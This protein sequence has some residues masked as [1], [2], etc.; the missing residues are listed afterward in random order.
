MKTKNIAAMNDAAALR[1]STVCLS[2]SISGLG[3]TRKVA[4]GEVAPA[5]CSEDMLHVHKDIVESEKLTKVR[6]VQQRMRAAVTSEAT[7]P[8]WIKGGFYLVPKARLSAI[9]ARLTDIDA[10]MKEAVAAFVEEYPAAV[11]ASK[12]KL[13]PLAKD[14][15]YPDV[16]TVAAAFSAS[17]FTV[18]LGPAQNVDDDIRAI[19]AAKA[20]KAWAEAVSEV[21]TILRL[22]MLDLVN[23]MS[24]LTAPPADG[25]L[26]AFRGGPA[27]DKLVAFL[28]EW[29]LRNVASDADLDAIVA[30]AKALLVGVDA[31]DLKGADEIT[32]E[33]RNA[34]HED[35][36]KVAAAL[37]PLV[38][39]A[40]RRK[41]AW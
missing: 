35:M 30:K 13:G 36:E 21:R 33:I 38:G 11:E 10:E 9:Y 37:E 26:R 6:T 27:L 3:T 20:E 15:D 7:T 39:K 2:L 24:E 17:W 31:A 18:D 41:L 14:A 28:E 23:K 16:S 5:G 25:S 12:A 34:V 29:P 8:T 40:P 4:S 32:Q 22:T 1:A 19:E